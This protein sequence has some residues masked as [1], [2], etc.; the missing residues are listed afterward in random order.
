MVF[1]FFYTFHS[2]LS[3]NLADWE[4]FG[5]YFSVI[6]SIANLVLFIIITIYVAQ[7]Q[8]K[9]NEN[10]MMHNKQLHMLDYK[11]KRIED[12]NNI[13]NSLQSIAIIDL[14]NDLKLLYIEVCKLHRSINLYQLRNIDLFGDDVD[15]SQSE[16]AAKS[17][18]DHVKELIDIGIVNDDDNI[19]RLNSELKEIDTSLIRLSKELQ[20][21]VTK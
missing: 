14:G 2:G 3:N 18:R 6:V 4:A 13:I 21:R 10:Q 5:S 1:L 20:S 17:F 8:D 12:L 15:Y 19:T 9:T 11:W 7:L 16:N